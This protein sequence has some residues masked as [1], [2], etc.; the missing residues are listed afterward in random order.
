MDDWFTVEQIDANTYRLSEYRHWEKTHCYLLLGTERALL[1]DTGLGIGNIG[2]AVRRL[3]KL[4]VVAMATHAHWDH[5]GGHACCA[6]YYVHEAEVAWLRGAFPLPLQAVRSMVVRDCV[7]P[8]GFD[9]EQYTIFAG[10]EARI[11]RDGDSIDLGSRSVQALHTPGHSPGHMCVWEEARGYLWTGDL[12]YRGTLYASYPSTDPEAYAASAKR[13]AALP[14]QRVLPGHHAAD[15][16]VE[17]VRQVATALQRLQA[18]GLLRHG[19]GRH[20]FDGFDIC[21]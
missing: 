12:V 9:V 1:I 2:D 8:E 15:V 20:A 14:I 4:P 3:T 17:M 5:V 6:A 21:L 18:D 10:N 7:L 13:V 16:R 19:S 11:L